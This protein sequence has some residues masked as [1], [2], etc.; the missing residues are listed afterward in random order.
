RSHRQLMRFARRAATSC[1]DAGRSSALGSV[2]F[3]EPRGRLARVRLRNTFYSG[4]FGASCVA[5]AF[6]SAAGCG[7]DKGACTSIDCASETSNPQSAQGG[8]GGSSSGSALPGGDLLAGEN[9]SA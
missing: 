7:G 5:A 3:A 2:I 8:S 1:F 6:V 4:L 9:S